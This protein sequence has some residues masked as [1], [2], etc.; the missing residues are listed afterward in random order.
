M[1]TS[2]KNMQEPF[3]GRDHVAEVKAIAE[4]RR[5]KRNAKSQA[6]INDL[7]ESFHAPLGVLRTTGA[8]VTAFT[9]HYREI[10]P[11]V[12]GERLLIP[13]QE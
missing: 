8:T 3:E 4:L 11:V 6:F 1:I 7:L 12:N 5:R 9:Y 10:P 13:V 2:L